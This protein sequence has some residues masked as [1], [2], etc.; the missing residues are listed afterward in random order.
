MSAFGIVL[1]CG[2]VSAHGQERSYVTRSLAAVGDGAVH[3]KTI[4]A[5][6]SAAVM[7]TTSIFIVTFEECGSD[8]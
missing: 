4:D 2:G 3:W 1:H 5:T 6:T 7:E 8:T